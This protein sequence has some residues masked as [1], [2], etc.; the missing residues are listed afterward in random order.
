VCLTAF[1]V[2]KFA[3][4]PPTYIQIFIKNHQNFQKKEK[5]F[6]A[7]E[8]F[9]LRCPCMIKVFVLQYTCFAYRDLSGAIGSKQ[10]IR[11]SCLNQPA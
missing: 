1:C 5:V 4:H 7:V 3:T 10:L 6:S 2:N 8:Q 9:D 11:Q